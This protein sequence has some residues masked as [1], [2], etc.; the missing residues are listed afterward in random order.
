MRALDALGLSANI[1]QH[2]DFLLSL[3]TLIF[4]PK[5]HN[6]TD[7]VD[8]ESPNRD[9]APSRENSSVV[10]SSTILQQS[11]LSMI[12][13]PLQPQLVQRSV[14]FEAIGKIWLIPLYICGTTEVRAPE[15]ITQGF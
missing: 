13:Y 8:P 5:Y 1:F 6:V 7:H 12:P 15:L 14:I 10:S 4:H 11:R 3:Y 9:L 2:L